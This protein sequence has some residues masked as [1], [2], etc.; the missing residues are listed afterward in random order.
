MKIEEGYK[1]QTS[2]NLKCDV[3]KLERGQAA[4]MQ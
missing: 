1:I 3:L 4:K 2:A